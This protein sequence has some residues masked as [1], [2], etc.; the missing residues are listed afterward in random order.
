MWRG[1]LW[2]MCGAG[3]IIP[4]ACR[5]LEILQDGSQILIGMKTPEQR[6]QGVCRENEAPIGTISKFHP[7]DSIIRLAPRRDEKMVWRE[8]VGEEKASTLSSP[9]PTRHCSK[10]F[11]I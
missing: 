1:Q 6:K 9:I 4:P 10:C 2:E 7:Q 11:T 8:K 3:G 5:G